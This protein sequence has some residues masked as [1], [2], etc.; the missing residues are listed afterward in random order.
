MRSYCEQTQMATPGEDR[1]SSFNST[2]PG[3]AGE[4]TVEVIVEDKER[5]PSLKRKKTSLTD[6]QVRIC[7]NAAPLAR[8]FAHR[9][10]EHIRP[11]LDCQ[12]NCGFSSVCLKREF[13]IELCLNFPVQEH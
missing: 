5:R 3:A 7:I 9:K 4:D 6:Y 10:N 2:L 8:Q 12:S 13:K 11:L 1:R